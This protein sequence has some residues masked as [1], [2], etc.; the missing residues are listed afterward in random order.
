ME[1]NIALASSY[2][3]ADYNKVLLQSLFDNNRDSKITVYFGYMDARMETRINEWNVYFS[4][5]GNKIVGIKIPEEQYVDSG[6]DVLAWNAMTY[7]RHAMYNL[8]PK[9]LD[10]VMYLGSNVLVIKNLYDLYNMDLNGKTIAGPRLFDDFELG[11]NKTYLETVVL[12]IIRRSDLRGADMNSWVVPSV[13]I[14]DM[15][16][17]RKLFNYQ[18]YLKFIKRH[19]FRFLDEEALNY[20]YK[21]D[22]IAFIEEVYN[23]CTEVKNRKE[24]VDKA[25]IIH[26]GGSTKAWNNKGMT[27]EADIW[28]EYAKRTDQYEDYLKIATRNLWNI[29][30]SNQK[31]QGFREICW[32]KYLDARENNLLLNNLRKLGVTQLV[33]YGNTMFSKYVRKDLIENGIKIEA[34][35]DG[36]DVKSNESIL[37]HEFLNDYECYCKADGILIVLPSDIVARV[38][39]FFGTVK[40]LQLP[41]WDIEEV[42]D[43]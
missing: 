29:I 43:M 33:L 21:D 26:Y 9:E 30:E 15:V 34:I 17:W 13:L 42:L 8:L 20:I 41:I 11:E 16:R 1:M 19:P 32:K 2:E 4:K 28:W 12:P 31:K 6:I 23:V 22:K 37:V 39:H 3:Y 40:K 36:Y 14:I 18:A 27:M 10:R 5:T 35:I 25:K 24:A 7:A 38:R